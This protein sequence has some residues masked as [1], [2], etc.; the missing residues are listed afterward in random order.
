MAIGPLQNLGGWTAVWYFLIACTIAGEPSALLLPLPL[1]LT[2][3]YPLPY[4]PPPLTYPTPDLPL[5]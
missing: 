1:P 5:T 3:P 4:L 2:Y